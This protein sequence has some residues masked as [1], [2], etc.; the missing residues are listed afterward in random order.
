MKIEDLLEDPDALLQ[1]VGVPAFLSLLDRAAG[2]ITSVTPLGPDQSWD[3]PE[4]WQMD[5]VA[6]AHGYDALRR[7]NVTTLT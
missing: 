1:K 6:L 2:R 7:A 4:E 3:D 5:A